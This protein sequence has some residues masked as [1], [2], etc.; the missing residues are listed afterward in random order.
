M[1]GLKEPLKYKAVDSATGKLL[2]INGE[3][4]YTVVASKS[5]EASAMIIHSEGEDFKVILIIS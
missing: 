2:K 4:E 3:N 5:A 1:T